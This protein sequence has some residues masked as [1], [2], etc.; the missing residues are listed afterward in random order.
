M[1]YVAGKKP[2][3]GEVPAVM[4][5]NPKYAYNVS[6]ALR[7]MSCYGHP[8][9]WFTGDR[10][11]LDLAGK[12]RLPREERM[13][14]Y[15]DVELIQYDRPLEMFGP[16]VVPVAVEVRPN[17]ER[18]HQFDHPK[19]AVYVFGPE[20]GSIPP[21]VLAACHRFVVIPLRYCLNLACAVQTVMWDRAVKL[22]ETIDPE[23]VR[24][25]LD[26]DPQAMG[27]FDELSA[28]K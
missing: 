4:L 28:G 17:S 5:T 26:T 23:D 1:N 22:G 3:T 7:I 18:L 2:P 8:Q 12:K 10:V 13:K 16:D 21:P 11:T 6:M 19:N 25:Y 20:D 24:T 14:G 9:L 15:K 27:V